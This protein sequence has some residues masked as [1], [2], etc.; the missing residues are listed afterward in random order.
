MM[1]GGQQRSWPPKFA[2]K[3]S[4][5]ERVEDDDR[6]AMEVIPDAIASVIEMP[7]KS[8]IPADAHV[9]AIMML[10]A[11]MIVGISAGR[12]R[13]RSESGTDGGNGE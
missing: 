11:E 4:T 2:V 13:E 9:V 12:G 5:P 10:E 6:A 8:A 3:P 7:V 1:A